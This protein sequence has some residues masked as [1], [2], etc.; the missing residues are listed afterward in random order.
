MQVPSMWIFSDSFASFHCVHSHS[1]LYN[2]FLTSLSRRCRWSSLLFFC[3]ASDCVCND[4]RRTHAQYAKWCPSYNFA[5]CDWTVF[6]CWFFITSAFCPNIFLCVVV[7]FSLSRRCSFASDF[8][9]IISVLFAIGMF[10]LCS[11]FHSHNFFF[12]FFPHILILPFDMN[13]KCF[14]SYMWWKKTRFFVVFAGL[15]IRETT[16]LHNIS[17]VITWT[18]HRNPAHW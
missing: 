1:R 6:C 9:P 16:R 18:T 4:K 11:I 5:L 3:P 7:V 14:F 17:L 2:I 15:T 8:F 10:W 12:T 13:Y